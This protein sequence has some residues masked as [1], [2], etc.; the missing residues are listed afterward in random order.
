MSAQVELTLLQE[1]GQ[2][3]CDSPELERSLSNLIGMLRENVQADVGGA[4][5]YDALEPVVVSDGFT[6]KERKSLSG[7]LKLDKKPLGLKLQDWWPG[8]IVYYSL[9]GTDNGVMFAG[10]RNESGFTLK[11]R[12]LIDVL[13]QFA[14]I[15]AENSMLQRNAEN[16]LLADERDRIACELHDGLAQ[17][18][19]SMALQIKIC[20]RLLLTDI[21]EADAKLDK[22]EQLASAQIEDIR[23]YMRAL[24]DNRSISTD[25]L[26]IIEKHMRQ[27]CALHGLRSDFRVSGQKV[28]LSREINENLYYVICEGLANIAHHAQASFAKLTIVYEEAE[29]V[30]GIEDDGRGF[31]VSLLN[32]RRRG[33]GLENIEN[34][35]Q[36]IGGNVTIQSRINEGTRIIA[37]VPYDHTASRSYHIDNSIVSR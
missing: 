2:S 30:I 24:K 34:R 14:T 20:R 23:G 10:R 11:Q 16:R 7:L 9:N 26:S 1:A 36:R 37:C 33:M 17:S 21:G 22:L 12:A 28:A 32:K 5:I 31:D 8:S 19:Y 27:F 3:I 6:A 4:I 25:L 35:I 18:I 15:A 13:A 29:I